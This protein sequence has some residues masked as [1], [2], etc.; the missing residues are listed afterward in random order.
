MSTNITEKYIRNNTRGDTQAIMLYLWNSKS[1]G[2]TDGLFTTDIATGL[3]QR[4]K[5]IA[6]K[7]SQLVNRGLVRRTKLEGVATL[8][9]RIRASV[10]DKPRKKYKSRTT[11]KYKSRKLIGTIPGLGCPTISITQE[12]QASPTYKTSKVKAHNLVLLKQVVELI[13]GEYI[14][15]A[16]ALKMLNEKWHSA[17]K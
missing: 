12:V 7:L 14:D 1:N 4:P 17:P 8:V 11:K 9:W 3:N 10:P 6:S 16:K 15:N 5:D 2:A 13:E